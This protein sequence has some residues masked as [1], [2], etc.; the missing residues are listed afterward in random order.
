MRI[1]IFKICILIWQ[2]DDTNKSDEEIL[3]WFEIEYG[4]LARFAVQIGKYNQ[5]VCNGG[6]YQYYHNGF[7]GD[8]NTDDSDIPLH[9]ILVQLHMKAELK[10]ETSIKML[11]LLDEFYIE[12]DNEEYISDDYEE[13]EYDNPE[14]RQVT[15]IMIWLQ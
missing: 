5:Q 13:D 12:V 1:D 3:N 2:Q 10:D 15:N 9:Q 6:H 4:E 14:Y 8:N 11:S 7:A